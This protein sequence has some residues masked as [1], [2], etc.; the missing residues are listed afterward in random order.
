MNAKLLT[1]R[2]GNVKHSLLDINELYIASAN[3]FKLNI[4]IYYIDC[5]VC[6]WPQNASCVLSSY[7][8]FKSVKQIL[9]GKN[10]KNSNVPA[11]FVF[12]HYPNMYEKKLFRVCKYGCAIWISNMDIAGKSKN[13]R[14]IEY[15]N[16]NNSTSFLWKHNSK[17]ARM[18]V[19]IENLLESNIVHTEDPC[20]TKNFLHNDIPVVEKLLIIEHRGSYKKSFD[21]CIWYINIRF[22]DIYNLIFQNINQSIDMCKNRTA[23]HVCICRHFA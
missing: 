13:D 5:S 6:G 21:T 9:K 7:F 3:I 12:I 20:I 11:H 8:F 19:D 2:T 18:I 22:L 23:L 1:L 4:F 15:R 14:Y 10:R 17:P 16:V